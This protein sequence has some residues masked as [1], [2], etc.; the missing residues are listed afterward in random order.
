MKSPTIVTEIN[1]RQRKSTGRG[2]A[3]SERRQGFVP[4]VV[5][6]GGKEPIHIVIDIRE[7]NKIIEQG[8]VRTKI[9]NLKSTDNTDFRVLTKDIQFHPVKDIVEHVDFL[10]VNDKTDIRVEIKVKTINEELSPGIKLGGVVNFVR[11]SIEL[12]CQAGAIPQELIIDLKGL[13]IGDSVHISNIKL[14]S[15]VRPVIGD[16]DFTV[17]TITSVTGTST[18][19]SK[20]DESGETDNDDSREST[21]DS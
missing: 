20:T 17:A 6:G 13:V 2:D 21:G 9:F 19:D 3:R 4:G 11:H 8:G 7:I 10:R 18:E 15:G 12:I 16:R 14:P 1:Y 5:F